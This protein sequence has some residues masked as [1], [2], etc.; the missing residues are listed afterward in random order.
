MAS[1][2]GSVD[3]ARSLTF[4]TSLMQAGSYN[5]PRVNGHADNVYVL[6]LPLPTD[7]V[8]IGAGR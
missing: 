6:G 3:V 1:P 7:G 4:I 2:L 8:E 5:P